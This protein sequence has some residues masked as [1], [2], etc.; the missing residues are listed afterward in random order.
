MKS[1]MGVRNEHVWFTLITDLIIQYSIT[2]I[3]NQ[4]PEFLCILGIADETPNIPL[5]AQEFK[6]L[7][8]VFQFS[9]NHCL[10]GVNPNLR[11]YEPTVPIHSSSSFLPYHCLQEQVYKVRQRGPQS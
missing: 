10:S 2:N 11:T 3:P 6:F 1:E 7:V 9:A 8:N 4:T 5:L